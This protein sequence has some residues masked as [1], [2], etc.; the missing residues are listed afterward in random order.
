MNTSK[1]IIKYLAMAFALFLAITIV[2]GILQGMY[3][4]YDSFRPS[5]SPVTE[6]KISEI[7]TTINDI[8]IDL[9]YSSLTIKRGNKLTI[10]TNNSKITTSEEENK[11]N[12]KEEKHKWHKNNKYEITITIPLNIDINTLDINMGAGTLN[13]DTISTDKLTLDL[14]AGSTTINNINT[15]RA[16]INTGA[17]SF[18]INKGIINDLDLDIGVGETNVAAALT[19]NTKID[20]GVGTLKLAL[21][22][23]ITNYQIKVN[24]GIGKVTIDNQEVKDNEVVGS[25]PNTI[26]LSGGLG[27]IEV[28][29]VGR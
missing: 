25:G 14:G 21:E 12:I 3:A 22:G 6:S 16:N 8:N 20:T 11:L 18:T 1:K 24:K 28:Q 4:V 23:T 27:D 10:E 2:T 7:N 29:F 26:T 13:I 19:G 9:F 15:N 5:S 17:G